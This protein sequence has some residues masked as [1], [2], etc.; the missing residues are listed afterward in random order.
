MAADST[1]LTGKFKG[2]LAVACVIDG[3]N[4]MYPVGLGVFDS[5]TTENWSWFF[6]Q[7]KDAIGTPP[8]LSICTDAS[9]VILFSYMEKTC[10]L[11]LTTILLFSL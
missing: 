2:Q 10:S 6:Q 3:H 1:F 11:S 8:V 4:W 5:E 9:Q 7:L